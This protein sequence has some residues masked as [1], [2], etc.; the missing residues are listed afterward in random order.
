MAEPVLPIEIRHNQGMAIFMLVCA[1]FILGTT[2]L[3]GVSLNTLTGVVLLIVSIGYFTQ[4]GLVV[5]ERGFE[6]RNLL[7]MTM[8]RTEFTSLSDVSVEDGAFYVKRGTQREKVIGMRWFLSG[9]DI[10]RLEDAVRAASK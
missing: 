3:V 2:F 7:G 6:F 1:L 5:T 10:K 4:P 9:G 8:R